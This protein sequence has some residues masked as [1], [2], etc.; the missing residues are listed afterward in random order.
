[1]FSVK[2]IFKKYL[3]I[4]SRSQLFTVHFNDCIGNWRL[5]TNYWQFYVSKRF[6]ALMIECNILCTIIDPRLWVCRYRQ[7]GSWSKFLES[8]FPLTINQYTHIIPG[9]FF[10][11]WSSD[12]WCVSDS[13]E[14]NIKNTKSQQVPWTNGKELGAVWDDIFFSLCLQISVV[15]LPRRNWCINSLS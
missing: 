14:S 15:M 13:S 10:Y 7:R 8:R 12:S 6:S 9:H 1:M 2:V 11:L 5:W 3:G 4:L